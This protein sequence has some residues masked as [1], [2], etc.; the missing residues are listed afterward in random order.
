MDLLHSNPRSCLGRTGWLETR[1]SCRTRLNGQLSEVG[2]TGAP[3]NLPA[4]VLLTPATAAPEQSKQS[5]GGTH[6]ATPQQPHSKRQL[7][8]QR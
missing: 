6:T 3:R 2:R 8:G 5:P 4:N 1:K 7:A